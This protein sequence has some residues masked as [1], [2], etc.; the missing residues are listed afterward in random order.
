MTAPFKGKLQVEAYEA[1]REA[2][3]AR[4]GLE[5]APLYTRR[6]LGKSWEQGW[7]DQAGEERAAELQARAAAEP[8]EAERPQNPRTFWPVDRPLPTAYFRQTIPCP[9]CLRVLLD[10]L[11]QA[12]VVRSIWR[13]VVYLRCRGPGCAHEWKLPEREVGA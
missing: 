9:K 13:G 1:G 6:T 10:D 3:R 7:R 11:G 5:D 2:R 8:V 12:V 4:K